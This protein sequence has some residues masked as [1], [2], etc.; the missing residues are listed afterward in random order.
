MERG[1]PWGKTASRRRYSHI[2]SCILDL[3]IHYIYIYIYRILDVS[4]APRP[5][6][7]IHLGGQDIS[8]YFHFNTPIQAV[9]SPTPA[10]SSEAGMNRGISAVM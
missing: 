7:K 5:F 9:H 1:P 10:L 6:L 4:E 3:D 8:L 2:T